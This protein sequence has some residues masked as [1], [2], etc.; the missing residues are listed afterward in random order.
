MDDTQTSSPDD[1]CS[2]T[3]VS[4][5]SSSSSDT[6]DTLEDSRV[7]YN[8]EPQL[9]QRYRETVP[10]SPRQLF[11]LHTRFLNAIPEVYSKPGVNSEPE[12][13]SGQEISVEPEA[14][15][16]GGHEHK[17]RLNLVDCV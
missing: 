10:C 6:Y 8:E 16:L 17:V 15:E 4:S 7:V 5:S 2:D 11:S 3:S 14:L 1:N 9:A 13:D 12:M